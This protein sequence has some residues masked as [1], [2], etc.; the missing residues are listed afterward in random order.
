MKRP[1]SVAGCLVAELQAPVI[2]EPGHGALDDVASFPQ[3]A[4]MRTATHGQQTGDHQTHQ[5]FDDVRKAVAAVSLQGLG[6]LPLSPRAIGQR[7]KLLEHRLDQFFVP[8]VGRAH[9]D[10]QGDPLLVRN[11]VPL[12]TRFG[13]VG[14]VRSRVRPPFKALTEALSMTTRSM[15]NAPRL[16]SLVNNL[17]WTLSQTPADVHS[18]KRRQQVLGLTPNSLG[19]KRQ[20]MPPLSTYRMPSRH[21]RS[22]HRGWPPLGD[23]LCFGKSGATVDQSSSVNCVVMTA[24]LLTKSCFHAKTAD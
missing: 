24:S 20:A 13:A 15:F 10:D 16:A 5:Q 17:R 22:L 18:S 21:C 19:S 6:L 12:A 4:P 23:G 9:G 8:L 2:P 11:H 3:T 7:G 1:E 14:W